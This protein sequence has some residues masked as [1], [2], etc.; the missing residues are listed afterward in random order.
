MTRAVMDSLIH[1]FSSNRWPMTMQPQRRATNKFKETTEVWSATNSIPK[2][3]I[4]EPDSTI[5][6]AINRNCAFQVD[7]NSDL[8]LF[9]KIC[10]TKHNNTNLKVSISEIWILYLTVFA[11][12]GRGRFWK[13]ES[14][15]FH[16][17][18]KSE[19]KRRYKNT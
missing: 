7:F 5:S 17:L 18:R 19:G 1:R 11:S 8:A 13:I 3:T 14:N 4:D 6:I 12:K 9:R 15:G 16:C 10:Q 2:S